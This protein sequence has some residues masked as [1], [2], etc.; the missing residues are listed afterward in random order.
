M[1]LEIK[2]GGTRGKIVKRNARST[3]KTGRSE[4]TWEQS[5]GV[6]NANADGA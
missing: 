5:G 2:D 1:T 3:G 6:H 4:W